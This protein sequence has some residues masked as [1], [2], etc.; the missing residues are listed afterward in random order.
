MRRIEF[1][2]TVN[3]CS[4]PRWTVAL[5]LFLLS[6]F[7]FKLLFATRLTISLWFSTQELLV[8]LLVMRVRKI[9]LFPCREMHMALL[10]VALLCLRCWN[11]FCHH[12]ETKFFFV[13]LYDRIFLLGLP[14][15]RA[16]NLVY[17]RMALLLPCPFLYLA[18]ETFFAS[19]TRLNFS[20]CFSMTGFSSWISLWCMLSCKL[21]ICLSGLLENF[22]SLIFFSMIG[23]CQSNMHFGFEFHQ[24]MLPERKSISR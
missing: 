1:K 6:S 4:P 10:V 17:M 11:F 19:I 14:V 3:N 21:K 7:F 22:T 9:I 8:D 24:T 5:L 16:S 18:V 2:F 15:K 23:F 12:H 20:L 13:F